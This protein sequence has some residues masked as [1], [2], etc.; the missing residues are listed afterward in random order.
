MKKVTGAIALIAVLAAG[1]TGA[2]WYTG[3]MIEGEMAEAMQLAHNKL[4]SLTPTP[5]LNLSYRDYQRGIFSSQMR[6]VLTNATEEKVKPGEIT[7]YAHEVVILQT[8]HHGPFPLA[9][10]KQ[11]TLKPLLAS[12]H[13][14]LEENAAVKPLFAFTQGKSLLTADTRIAY[15]GDI[16]SAM[17]IIPVHFD[18]EGVKVDFS[19]AV[20]TLSADKALADVKVSANIDSF[21]L[22][23]SAATSDKGKMTFNGFTIDNVTH[24]SPAQIRVGTQKFGLK[25]FTLNTESGKSGS[26]E[27]FSLVSQFDEKDGV[28]VG[29][30][31]YRVAGVKIKDV[32]FG[33]G[34]LAIK[35]DQLDAAAFKKLY[36][37]YDQLIK[38]MLMNSDYDEQKLSEFADTHVPAL[39][40]SS[41]RFHIGPLRWQNS[42]GEGTVSLN[43][44][45]QKPASETFAGN[46]DQY[47]AGALKNIEMNVDLPLPMLTEV[48][49]Q[50]AALDGIAAS[51]AQD[52]AKMSADAVAHMGSQL[53]LSTVKDEVI[54][55]HFQYTDNAITLNGKKMSPEEFL[56]TY[57]PF[58]P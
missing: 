28:L 3:K 33:S 7:D 49:V 21:A 57:S 50:M 47:F 31:D 34:A 41:P 19:G 55:S 58:I 15:N 25:Q 5:L 53:Q 27:D 44:D 35:V 20:M 1:W 40:A 12:L 22:D 17:N 30:Q 11:F 39:L 45:L 51:D 52:A 37:S 9:Q 13:S 23:A 36:D 8:I 16:H 4:Q 26:V 6:M 32:D 10:L 46:E 48:L 2:S 56:G 18:K 14:E 54:S 43:I 24:L 38:Q 42:K 29:Q